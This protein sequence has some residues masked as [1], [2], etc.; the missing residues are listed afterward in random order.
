[1]DVG[2]YEYKVGADPLPVQ[3]TTFSA[4]GGTRDVT[5]R[6]HTATEADNYGFEIERRSGGATEWRSVGFV[7]GGGTEN[8]P[9]EYSFI[10]RG[11][12][13]GRYVY[14]LKQVDRS[15]SFTYSQTLEVEVAV[16]ERFALYQNYPNPFNPTTMIRFDVPRGVLQAITLRIYDTIGREVATLVNEVKEAG[17]YEVP[18]NASGLASG[19]Y[20]C[21]LSSGGFRAIEKLLL[22]K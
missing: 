5:L 7:K 3:L 1:M 10:D 9:M 2:A 19:V 14:R 13:S 11:L 15:G 4:V 18:F 16:P 17:S 21:R 8:R 12:A 22:A 6:W 20:Y